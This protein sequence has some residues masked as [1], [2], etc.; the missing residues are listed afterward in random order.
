LSGED[1]DETAAWYHRHQ[2]AR[3]RLVNRFSKITRGWIRSPLFHSSV[4]YHC[5]ND[6]KDIGRE[7]VCVSERV[8]TWSFWTAE[9]Y[10]PDNINTLYE[11]LDRLESAGFQ[12]ADR[13]PAKWLRQTRS[14][15]GSSLELYLTPKGK[16]AW[17]IGHYCDLPPFAD[18][19]V[20]TILCVTPSL[21]MLVTHFLLKAEE[22]CYFDEELHLDHPTRIIQN[23]GGSI[24]TLSPELEQRRLV[25]ERRE[26]RLMQA[27]AWHRAHFPGL[28]STHD[29]RV[30]ACEFSTIEGVVPLSRERS[31]LL[32]ALDLDWSPE[33]FEGPAAAERR[34]FLLSRPMRSDHDVDLLFLSST[35]ADFREQ[36]AEHYGHDGDLRYAARLDDYFRHTFARAALPRVLRFYALRTAEARDGAAGIVGSRN[37]SKALARVRA[38]TAQCMDASVI[39]RELRDAAKAKHL[40]R[41]DMDFALRAKGRASPM[42][43]GKVLHK[44]IIRD[45]QE[46]LE[47]VEAL[48]SGLHAQANLLSAHA[49]LKL[50]PWIIGLAILSLIAGMIAA[51]GPAKDLLTPSES[52][53]TAITAPT[54]EHVATVPKPAR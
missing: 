33:I 5:K 29:E 44:S 34:P 35:L 25:H 42:I 20:G 18:S 50:Q 1:G 14:L 53:N 7:R 38:D 26:A 28:L 43:L 3:Y 9:F 21:T 2:S 11:A 41:I 39:A 31:N 13:N 17:G 16:Q 30:S 37:A 36:D 32:A 6:L 22:R 23:P 15:P 52:R 51:I 54:S 46:L 47:N 49:N 8:Q 19:A 40:P 48:N 45:A 27:T 12:C 10:T 4:A 24:S